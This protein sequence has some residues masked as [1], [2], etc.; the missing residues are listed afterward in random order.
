MKL[1]CLWRTGYV[2][3]SLSEEPFCNCF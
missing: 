1:G 2:V 3:W